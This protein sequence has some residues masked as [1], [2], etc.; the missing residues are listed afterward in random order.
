MILEDLC[1]DAVSCDQE[2]RTT[3][4]AKHVSK[5][6]RYF[7]SSATSLTCMHNAG[8]TWSCAADIYLFYNLLKGVW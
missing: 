8:V 1:V 3:G 6:L 4:R 7:G 5:Q 2:R